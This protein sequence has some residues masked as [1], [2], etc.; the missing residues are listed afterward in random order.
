MLLWKLCMSC[1]MMCAI[2]G[3]HSTPGGAMHYIRSIWA[4]EGG[5]GACNY[6]V[7]PGAIKI[8]IQAKYF[9][10][11][12]SARLLELAI[13]IHIHGEPRPVPHLNL[14][15]DGTQV[16]RSFAAFG[17]SYAPDIGYGDLYCIGKKFPLTFLQ[18]EGNWVWWNFIQQ[19]MHVQYNNLT[20]TSV[21]LLCIIASTPLPQNSKS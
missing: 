9:P 2:Y 18:C 6:H 20:C 5:E 21:C 4:A 19:I 14:Y 15:F 3:L 11:M 1:K 8:Q 16:T 13:A 17:S 12:E 7:H 10:N